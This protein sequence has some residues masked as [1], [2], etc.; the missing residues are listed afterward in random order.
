MSGY[1]VVRSTQVAAAPATLHALVDDFHEWR[2]WSP[3]E[4]VDPDL[5]RTYSGPERGVGAHYA[6]RGNRKAGQGAM[7]ITASAPERIEVRLVF[8]KPF[9][10]TNDVWFDLVPS[11]GGTAVEWGMRGEQQGFWGFVGRFMNMDFEKGL[12]R[13]KAAAESRSDCA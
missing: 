7:E 13:L 3:W 2:A 8:L 12:A 5:E 10:A 9:A 4:D 1:T 11:D 6:W